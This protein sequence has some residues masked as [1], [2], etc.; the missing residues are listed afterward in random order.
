MK[1]C[2]PTRVNWPL[3]SLTCALAGLAVPARAYTVTWNNSTG[4]LLWSTPLNWSVNAAPTGAD[5]V[6]FGSA[7]ATN[8][9]GAVNNIVSTS[10]TISNLSYTALANN[11]FYHT[12]LINPGQTLTVNSSSTN[13]LER[14]LSVEGALGTD[15]Q[16]YAKIMGANASLVLGNLAAP[17]PGYLLYVSVKSTNSGL[18]RATLDLSA[19]DNFT[20]AGGFIAV[21]GDG[22]TVGANHPAGTILLAR[23]NLIICN[24]TA[25]TTGT[26][27]ISH[28]S[29]GN[30]TGDTENLL[31]LGQ[32]NTID[33]VYLRIGGEK[34][35]NGGAM[36][37][38]N[39]LTNPTLKLRGTNGVDGLPLLTI[40]D[41][42]DTATG[43]KSTG[44]LDL[45]GGTVDGLIGTLHVARTFNNGTSTTSSGSGDGTLT[46]TAGTIEVTNVF[47]GCQGR[48]N[49]G[50]GTGV[51]NV[52]SNAS[53][54]AGTLNIGGDAGTQLAT[55]N[56][57]LNVDGG[58]VM[59]SGNIVENDASAV[60]GCDGSSTINIT[61]NGVLNLQPPDDST[62]GNVTVDTLN[63]S[64]GTLT[65]YA[66]LGLST[67]NL[68]SPA[69]A[70][71]VY[72]GEALTAVGTGTN[73]IGTLTLNGNLVLTNATLHCDL[74]TSPFVANDLVN[75]TGILTLGGANQVDIN[76]VNGSL[77]TGDYLLMTYGPGLVG[78]ANNLQVAGPL[79]ASR[80]TFAFNTSVSPNVVVTVGGSPPT[81]LVWA[82]DG[83]GNA[84][85]LTN[86]VNWNAN[87]EKFYTF[88]N[89]TFDDTSLQ[90][91]VNLVGTLLPAGVTVNSTHNYTFAGT[92][93]ITGNTGLTN[94]GT[95]TL[96]LQ[97]SNDYTGTT[98][99]SA[100]KLV[101]GDGSTNGSLIGPIVNNS[102]LVF[103]RSDELLYPWVI[104]GSGSLTQAGAGGLRLNVVA[105]YTGPTAVEAGWL[106]I[107][108]GNNRL[109]TSTVLTLGSAGAAGEFYMGITTA[110][111]SQQLAGLAT[112]GLGGSVVNGGPL[113]TNLST[114]TLI[115]TSDYV[116]AG[117]LGGD[118]TN[119]N[120]L[121]LV[122]S[123][124]GK[125]TLSG[126]NTYTNTT[127]ISAGTLA[128][129][130]SGSIA[131]SPTI[132]VNS[133]ATF[134]VSGVTGGY[135]LA[136][137][138]TLIGVGTVTGSVTVASGA[139]LSPGTGIGTL[140]VNGDL[141]LSAG[142]I[143][144]F[145]V[146]TDT[147]AH[148][149]V[150]GLHQVAYG[151]TLLISPSGTGGAITNGSSVKLFNATTYTGSFA[152]IVP[153]TPAP[154]LVWD[155][156][157]LTAN[158]TLKVV[159]ISTT[160]TNLTL[161]VAGN[162]LDISWP[163]DHTGWRLE[164]QTNPPNAGLSTNWFTVPGSSATNRVIL[165]IDPA[166]GSAFYRLVYP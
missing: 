24:R 15:D 38:R 92:G 53:L 40:G 75:V 73:L 27:R 48:N 25:S 129:S 65:N 95:G 142:S 123:G 93:R 46:F 78:G 21:A 165:S 159:A 51:I 57:T 162:A 141:G 166:C 71:T 125:Q 60:S 98:V 18:H 16:I 32:E 19:L 140:T 117:R 154:G 113:D 108:G 147:L 9:P 135:V 121:A 100:G 102:A 54:V 106:R 26:I 28:N 6:V 148:D 79:A 103:D 8:T 3:L 2:K 80:Y 43:V 69:T 63:F 7:G 94:L 83:A 62:P 134:D 97:T 64:S 31:E 156:S 91:N 14:P 52:R 61:N 128:L 35:L 99:V 72:S 96:Y 150:T 12:T 58:T 153:A 124:A 109:P 77:G 146:N 67:L 85:D 87:T 74:D 110:A 36:R 132:T 111:R 88:D 4:D 133:G 143:N 37:F 10:L 45:S 84:W 50:T 1:T 107:S 105:T 11:G 120:N 155:T 49:N 66:L 144:V 42:W 149:L 115:T 29:A 68:L 130:D 138:Q 101:I 163:A 116:F 20:F 56:G 127:T 89:V 17:Q 33:T 157:G 44:V 70:F 122:K 145:E 41:N 112:A 82:G 86:A 30:D 114:L 81:N 22:G 139:T 5:S 119:E 137:G 59:V 118:G 131:G 126:V 23:T 152:A 136:G 164:G 55:G 160:P 39:G 90:T 158:G 47:L 104:S 76:M 34:A 161:A 151:G 13:N